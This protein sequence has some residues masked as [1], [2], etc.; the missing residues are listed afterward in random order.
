MLA[1]GTT[2]IAAPAPNCLFEDSSG[3]IWVSTSREFG[4]LND[5]RF[6]SVSGYP[7]DGGNRWSGAHVA[8][9]ARLY[10]LALEQGKAGS[11]F[12]AVADE[13]VTARDIAEIIGHVRILVVMQR[14]ALDDRHRAP[15]LRR[16]LRRHVFVG[17]GRRLVAQE[18]RRRLLAALQ[19][20]LFELRREAQTAGAVERLRIRGVAKFGQ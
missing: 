5:G 14:V 20:T 16:S 9:V 19:R 10:R 7:G 13:G 1:I 15:D 18:E 4:Y 3:R 11:S 12:H 8:D 6:V 17:G 2:V